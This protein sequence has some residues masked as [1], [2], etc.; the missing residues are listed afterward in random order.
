[1]TSDVLRWPRLL[2]TLLLL[3]GL[4][5]YYAWQAL[6]TPIGWHLCLSDPAAYDGYPLR[7]PLY[8]V[9]AVE[10][11]DRYILSKD[12]RDVPVE[13]PTAGLRPGQTVSVRA[14]FRA[15]DQV[16]VEVA[17]DL[18]RLRRAK[19]ALGLLGVALC[20]LA[21]P[22]VFAWGPGGLRTRGMDG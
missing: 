1:M 6:H 15:S 8:T 11:P 22:L 4:G 20:L 5:G 10:G 12:I 21:A 9:E 18:H 13:G 2:V 3:L 7:L 19:E 17:R 16:A 14:T